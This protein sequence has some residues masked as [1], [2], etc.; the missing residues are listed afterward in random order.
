MRVAKVTLEF[1]KCPAA[2]AYLTGGIVSFDH[3]GIQCREQWH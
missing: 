3:R 1:L 2:A